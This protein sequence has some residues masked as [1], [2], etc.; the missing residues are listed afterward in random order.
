MQLGAG[1]ALGRAGFVDVDVGRVAEQ[2]TASLA[3]E[4]A[5]ERDDVRAGATPHGEHLDRRAEPLTEGVARAARR[6][7]VVAVGDRMAVVGRRERVHHRRVH[8]GRVVT[9]EA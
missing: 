9:R 7:R 1:H 4:Q 8:A 5:R 6:P 3:R 2:T